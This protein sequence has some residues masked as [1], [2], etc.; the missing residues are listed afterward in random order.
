MK[1]FT[2]I[3]TAFTVFAGQAMASADWVCAKSVGN[4]VDTMCYSGIQVNGCDRSK[5]CNLF[6][7]NCGYCVMDYYQPSAKVHSWCERYGGHMAQ[8]NF[9]CASWKNGN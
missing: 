9:L 2:I 8:A 7:Y 5:H 1:Y 6:G 3:A 4:G